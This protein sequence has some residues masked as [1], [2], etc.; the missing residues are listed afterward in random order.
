[1]MN[2]KSDTSQL[3]EFEQLKQDKERLVKLLRATKEYREFADFADD[4]GSG[5]RYIPG[6][7][8]A[9]NKKKR[10]TGAKQQTTSAYD[11]YPDQ[12]KEK[13]Q[14]VPED[15]Y[16][17]AHDVREQTSG[18]ITPKIMNKLLLSLNKIWRLREKQTEQ[19]VKS[20][21]QAEIEKLK[22][23]KSMKGQ[24]DS[25]QAKKSLA[26]TRTQL[27]KAEDKL[28][29]YSDQLRKLKNLPSGMNMIDEALM[30]G[31]F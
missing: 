30:I 19:R 22:R 13:N 3:L 25:V 8:L 11:F 15:A 21:Y 31:K 5:V 2:K 20:K 12:E 26:R 6:E 28:K 27:K 24:Y 10:G 23:E 1:M 18:E 4:S 9:P 16:N 14:W 17:L 29:D 7:E